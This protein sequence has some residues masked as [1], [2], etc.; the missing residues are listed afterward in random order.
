MR[1]HVLGWPQPLH[2]SAARA[3]NGVASNRSIRHVLLVHGQ[4][5]AA[6]LAPR[7]ACITTTL[8]LRLLP[9][10]LWPVPH[11]GAIALRD[12]TESG[13]ILFLFAFAQW[14]EAR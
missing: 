1:P 2:A 8:Y 6:L 7:H 4:P 9:V 14:L 3:P 10:A 13:V 11:A 12:F 5:H